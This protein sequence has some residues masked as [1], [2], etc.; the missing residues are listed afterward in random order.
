LYLNEVYA[1]TDGVNY[2]S[3]VRAIVL[4]RVE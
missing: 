1:D 2:P 3:N 4:E